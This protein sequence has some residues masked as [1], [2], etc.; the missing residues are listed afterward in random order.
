MKDNFCMLV[1]IAVIGFLLYT[2]NRKY[3][4]GFDDNTSTKSNNLVNVVAP[5]P[6]DINI[7]L[8]GS[9][10]N[11]I[12]DTANKNAGSLNT[13]SAPIT[14]SIPIDIFKD[15]SPAIQG[16]PSPNPTKFNGASIDSSSTFNYA[17][18]QN[19]VNNT[20]AS[21]DLLPTI[22]TTEY[23]VNNPITT[24]YD[25][26]LTVNTVEKIGVDTQGS[27]KKNASSDLRG[28]IPCPKFVIGPWNNSTI[29]PDTN[30]KSM[31]A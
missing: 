25:A 27:S 29:D 7:K 16:L 3:F 8:I 26:N 18:L 1:L 20:L 6:T 28:N 30:L 17:P 22:E 10:A 11:S 2:M 23:N 4:E 21:S 24:Y 31:Y 19:S 13:S 9:A 15:P 14:N 12:A 5:P